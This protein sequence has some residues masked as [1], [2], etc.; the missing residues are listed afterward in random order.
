[1]LLIFLIFLMFL[2]RLGRLAVRGSVD[3]PASQRCGHILELGHLTNIVPFTWITAVQPL[4]GLGL[5]L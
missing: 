2:K 5:A 1:M 3:N 4:R